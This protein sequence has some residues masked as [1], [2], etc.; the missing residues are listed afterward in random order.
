MATYLQLPD[1]KGNVKSKSHEYWIEIITL[2]FSINRHISTLPGQVYDREMSQPTLS[3]L[4]LIKHI[5]NSSVLLFQNAC[6][7]K[8][9]STA[10]IDLCQT[11][12]S[13]NAYAQIK[14][15]NIIITS[16]QL[17]ADSNKFKRPLEHIS[18]NFD[19]IQYRYTPY[20]LDNQAQ[21]PLTTGYDLKNATVI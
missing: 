21:S 11:N 18:I 6:S 3:E 9:I 10:T 12:Q 4:K 5:D 14:L 8:S 7:A 16:Y 2:S 1:I 15:S 13:S 17:E 20:D 19:E